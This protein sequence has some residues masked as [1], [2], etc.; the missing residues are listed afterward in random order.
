M[1]E[2]DIKLAKWLDGKMEGA[3]LEEFKKSPEYHTYQKIKDYSAELI[4]PQVDIDTLYKNVAKSRNQNKGVRKL[5]PWFA[6]I[7][8]VL[9]IALGN[10]TCIRYG[11]VSVLL[12]LLPGGEVT[13]VDTPRTAG[14]LCPP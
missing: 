10:I 5:T 12:Q 4:A 11:N 13:I 6:K 7:A 1:K 8:A 3:E 14:A 2:E 9:I